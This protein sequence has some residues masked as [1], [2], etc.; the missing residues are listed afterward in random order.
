MSE[1]MPGG[2]P[3]YMSDKMPEY[4]SNRTSVSWS[5]RIPNKMSELMSDRMSEKCLKHARFNG[6]SNVRIYIQIY[7]LKCHGGDHSK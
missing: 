7:V 3:E 1:D 6:R 2:M 5:E 4:M